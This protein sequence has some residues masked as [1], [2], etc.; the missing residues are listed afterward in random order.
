MVEHPIALKE[1]ETARVLSRKA[2][3][4][5]RGGLLSGRHRRSPLPDHIARPSKSWTS[6]R[7]SIAVS[8][9][10]SENQYIEVKGAMPKRVTWARV[11]IAASISITTPLAR[12][13]R[14]RN[15]PT[16]DGPSIS[17]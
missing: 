17:A 5:M 11:N 16:I 8:F 6:G 10:V 15:A 13:M 7:Q 2:E 12:V 14:K 1:A 4:M 9:L 3:T